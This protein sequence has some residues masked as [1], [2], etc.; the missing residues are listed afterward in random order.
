MVAW[1]TSQQQSSRRASPQRRPIVEPGGM[2]TPEEWAKA[3]AEGAK[4]GGELLAEGSALL[5]KV[6]SSQTSLFNITPGATVALA[7]GHEVVA[8]PYAQVLGPQAP[9]AAAASSMSHHRPAPQLARPMSAPHNPLRGVAMSA[10]DRPSSAKPRLHASAS[11]A[12]VGRGASAAAS[13]PSATGCGMVA[14]SSAATLLTGGAAGGGGGGPQPHR[15]APARPNGSPPK[16]LVLEASEFHNRFKTAHKRAQRILGLGQ[17]LLEP[18]DLAESITSVRL[19]RPR[20]EQADNQRAKDLA[21][22]VR[23]ATAREPKWSAPWLRR[24]ER[25]AASMRRHVMLV[26]ASAGG[27]NS[28]AAMAARRK[29]AAKAH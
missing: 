24:E 6:R 14:S 3:A 26:R 2:K 8:P 15:P 21:N 22:R 29:A 18:F 9:S 1:M 23:D 16:T 7:G 13:A 19:A 25:V 4:R 27:S 12:C 5:S 28:K 11:A 17:D 20:S 10:A